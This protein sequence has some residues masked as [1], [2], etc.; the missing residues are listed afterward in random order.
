MNSYCSWLLNRWS[1][2]LNELI[3]L[4]YP[5]HSLVR[6]T[7]AMCSAQPNVND[8]E[9]WFN[10]PSQKEGFHVFSPRIMV[11]TTK[12]KH[13]QRYGHWYRQEL[14]R[15]KVKTAISDN[16]VDY[17]VWS[18]RRKGHV[19][20][21]ATWKN[22][23]NSLFSNRLPSLWKFLHVWMSARVSLPGDAN[24]VRFSRLAPSLP[25]DYVDVSCA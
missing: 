24:T 9:S 3:F 4:S 7:K 21:V 23:S 25:F 8:V 20:F 12:T 6:F 18:L 22:S 1:L 17:A 19:C 11:F 16:L 14:F 5:A 10:E 13:F 2:Q 15:I